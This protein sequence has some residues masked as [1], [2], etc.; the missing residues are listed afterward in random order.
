MDRPYDRLPEYRCQRQDPSAS[1][2]PPR[3]WVRLWGSQNP[4]THPTNPIHSQGTRLLLPHAPQIAHLPNG[5]LILA[6]LVF[7]LSRK[8]IF[9]LEYLYLPLKRGGGLLS[10]GYC[11]RLAQDE[12]NH[13]LLRAGRQTL[14]IHRIKAGNRT[15]C[16]MCT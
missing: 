3:P 1:Y 5:T 11:W 7:N 6:I 15:L 8:A 2:P 16:C 14:A 12:K 4:L 9:R 13:M 10:A